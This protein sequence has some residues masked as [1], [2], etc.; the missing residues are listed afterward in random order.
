[1]TIGPLTAPPLLAADNVNDESDRAALQEAIGQLPAD[2]RTALGLKILDGFT[3]DDVA[4]TLD[5]SEATA[6][7]RVNA[8]LGSIRQDLQ[9]FPASATVRNSRTVNHLALPMEAF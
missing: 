6:R 7:R 9:K 1:M 2:Q 4:A 5:C 8:A 3:Y